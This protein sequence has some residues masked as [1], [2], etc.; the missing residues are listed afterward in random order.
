MAKS[1]T[2]LLSI[3]DS[4]GEG[5]SQKRQKDL[6]TMQQSR[7][8][9]VGS[10]T[11]YEPNLA[12]A[13]GLVCLVA[14]AIE[15]KRVRRLGD[16]DAVSLTLYARGMTTG[17]ISAHFAEAYEMSVSKD[18]IGRV[19]DGV[20]EEMTVWWSRPSAWIWMG[21]RTSRGCGAVKVTVSL[22]SSGWPASTTCA[23]RVP[24]VLG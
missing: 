1:E 4:P 16:V 11:F 22:R 10:V 8:R 9:P 17:D 2:S 21:A 15:P 12:S 14:L 5:R 13:T 6:S 20:L 24:Q 3:K 18:T 23:V 19:T 7:A